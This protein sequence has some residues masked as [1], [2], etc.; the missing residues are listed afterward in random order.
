MAHAFAYRGLIQYNNVCIH[1]PG[2]STNIC[3]PL[4]SSSS[5][6]EPHTGIGLLMGVP[7]SGVDFFF[8]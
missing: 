2:I 8:K 6:P 5:Q 3:P 4:H 1:T 7:V